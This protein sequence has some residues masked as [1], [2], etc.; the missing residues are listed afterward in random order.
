[1]YTTLGIA[2]AAASL[3]SVGLLFD[4]E[5]LSTDEE[6]NVEELLNATGSNAGL[7]FSFNPGTISN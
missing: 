6:L 4:T 7:F 1:M 2:L 3:K 5:L